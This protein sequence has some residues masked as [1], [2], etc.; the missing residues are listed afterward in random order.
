MS[1]LKN[2]LSAANGEIK[3]FRRI[4][5]RGWVGGVCAGIAYRLGTAAW[6][7]RLVA[8]LCLWFYGVGLLAYALLW[9]FVPDAGLTPS[10]YEERVGGK[11]P[12]V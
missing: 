3:E 9:L 6:L 12:A 10:D 7:V 8:F 11:K 1:D 2:V 4:F 5:S